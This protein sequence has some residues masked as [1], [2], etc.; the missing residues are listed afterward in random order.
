MVLRM[1]IGG[2]PFWCEAKL[3]LE[4]RELSILKQAKT[5]ACGQRLGDFVVAA[6]YS[7]TERSGYT[8]EQFVPLRTS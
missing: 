5:K 3:R 1:L 8:W 2:K 7:I 4:M 6:G